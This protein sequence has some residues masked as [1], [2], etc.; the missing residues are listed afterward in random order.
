MSIDPPDAWLVLRSAAG[1][2][3]QILPVR[4]RFFIGRECVGIEPD[5]R[6]LID[7]PTV[8]RVHA[9]IRLDPVSHQAFIV[10]TSSNGTRVNGR[11]I[12][13]AAPVPLRPGDQI[14]VGTTTVEFQ[15]APRPAATVASPRAT[16]KDVGL[17]RMAMV[18]GDIVQYSTISE[19]TDAGRLTSTLDRLYG[20]LFQLLEA[21]RG[22][23]NNFVGDAFFAIWE[24]DHV[25]DAVEQ[26]VEFALA[27][28]TEV[29][30]LGATLGVKGPDGSPLR[31]GWAVAEGLV[32]VSTMT[33]KLVTVVGDATNLAFRISGLAARS[34]RG[35]VLVTESVRQGAGDRFRFDQEEEVVV[36]GRLAPARIY[37]AHWGR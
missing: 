25:P 19:Y 36:K 15:A 11:R 3:D 8:S 12:E 27:A 37:A 32:G 22:T 14:V 4:E 7:E 31:M 26:A 16:V 28:A 33:G 2:G 21:H 9:E 23:L 1:L 35:D 5:Q 24:V 18:V 29:E 6:L 20:P 34:G 30:L 13:R 10:D 17:V